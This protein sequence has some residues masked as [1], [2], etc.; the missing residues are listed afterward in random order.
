MENTDRDV[1]KIIDKLI[2]P[3]TSTILTN[4]VNRDVNAIDNNVVDAVNN[5]KHYTKNSGMD[6]FDLV[7]SCYVDNF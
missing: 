5:V 1:D 3:D 7:R 2:N 4:D 6:L